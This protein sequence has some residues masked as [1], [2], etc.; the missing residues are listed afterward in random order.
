MNRLGRNMRGPLP[1]GWWLVRKGDPARRGEVG[2][3]AEQPARRRNR[4]REAEVHGLAADLVLRLALMRAR[5]RGR[6]DLGRI[7]T[8]HAAHAAAARHIPHRGLRAVIDA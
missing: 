1:W 3:L 7:L 4:E 5:G 2:G 8:E 6:S